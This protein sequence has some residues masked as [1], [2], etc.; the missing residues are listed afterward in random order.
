MLMLDTCALLWMAQGGGRL[1]ASVLQQI[2]ASP[3]V[4]I[5]AISGFEVAL[6]HLK[7]K[8]SLPA[9]P[10]AWFQTVVAHHDLSVVPLDLDIAIA[11][12]QL[13]FFHNDPCD[14]FIIASAQALDVPV[15]T[16]D[17]K[18]RGYDIDI[19]F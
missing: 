18:F 19:I 2:E 16:G 9:D 17:E 14:R 7:G 15:V 3:V 4:Y 8:L 12:T 6:K 10:A 11:A 5:S 13:P 1:N